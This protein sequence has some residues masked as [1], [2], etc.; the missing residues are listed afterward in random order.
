MQKVHFRVTCV[1]LKRL[2]LSSLLSAATNRAE[3]WRRWKMSWDLYKVARGLDQKDEKNQVAKARL[4]RRTFH[5]P[6]LIH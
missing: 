5:E 4:R 3:A 1:A 6:N 2:L